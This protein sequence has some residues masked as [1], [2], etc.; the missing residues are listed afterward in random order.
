[1][2]KKPIHESTD[3]YFFLS[4]QIAKFIM[5]AD[6]INS[7]VEP[8]RTEMTDIQNITILHVCYLDESESK[9]IQRIKTYHR[10]VLQAVANQKALSLLKVL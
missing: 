9:D 8:V 3:S 6:V 2:Q 4:R 10:S 5:I 1:M 7:Y